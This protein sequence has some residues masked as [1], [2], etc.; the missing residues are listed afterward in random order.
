MILDYK[1]H[2]VASGDLWVSALDA[3]RAKRTA[4]RI[5][6]DNHDLHW[7]ELDSVEVVATSEVSRD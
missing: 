1:I 2:W 3:D 6:G 5:L 4:E 7:N